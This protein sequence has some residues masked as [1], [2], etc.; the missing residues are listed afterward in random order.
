MNGT[1][2]AY[3]NATAQ[4]E[5]SATIRLSSSFLPGMGWPRAA[6]L[7]S[8]CAKR[9]ILVGKSVRMA[10][11]IGRYV[12]FGP[13]ATGGMATVHLARLHGPLG[14][15]KT[16]AAKRLRREHAQTELALTLIDEARLQ[17][18]VQ[19]A[20]VV[21][22]VD[23]VEDRGELIVLMEHVLGESLAKLMTRMRE[24]RREMEV[25][26]AAAVVR[27]AL[28]GLAAAHEAR[29]EDDHL[30]GIVHRDVSP[31]NLLVGVDGVTRVAN[32][33]IAKAWGRLQTTRD[34]EVKGKLAYMSPEQMRGEEVDVRTDVFASA[35]V[36]W[37]LLTGTRLFGG[38]DEKSTIGKLLM[39][40]IAP[41][42]CHNP[43]VTPALDRVVLRGLARDP[44][45]R[46]ADA[47][48]FLSALSEAA[49]VATAAEVGTWVESLCADEIAARRRAITDAERERDDASSSVA[50]SGEPTGTSSLSAEDTVATRPTFVLAG[51][52]APTSRKRYVALI[53][54]A[55]TGLVV[56]AGLV[57]RAGLSDEGS[58][59]PSQA[60][61]GAEARAAAEAPP[62]NDEPSVRAEPA[63]TAAAAPSASAAAAR[64]SH[65]TSA[66]A[67]PPR[68]GP[69]GPDCRTPYTYDA[70]GRKRY[71]RECLVK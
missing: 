38:D 46:Y 70:Q 30:L 36:L 51:G 16:L 3:P 45:E 13:I 54:A 43:S 34:G 26:I 65:A 47:R 18:R 58:E 8:R 42:S 64:P 1:E 6:A 29:D 33:G 48:A 21:P 19:H 20:N 7:T 68:R 28:R 60:S 39:G 37:E 23:V 22:I 56:A 27:D 44:A 4:D 25:S 50:T 57:L 32:F 15:K 69:T 63:T 49:P 67:A 41:P 12:V 35:I 66:T 14:F 9:A 71:R 59:G 53:L 40:E 52:P 17:A 5:R 11:R 10:E 61:P 55:G 24:A 62:P 31:H 2:R